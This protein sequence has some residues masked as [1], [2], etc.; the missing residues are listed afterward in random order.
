MRTPKKRRTARAP[1][2]IIATQ[3]DEAT[4]ARYQLE[5]VYCGKKTCTRCPH[6]PYWYAYLWAGPRTRSVYIGRTLKVLTPLET[7]AIRELARHPVPGNDPQQQLAALA[8]RAGLAANSRE[9]VA[10]LNSERSHGRR[11]RL[12]TAM[13]LERDAAAPLKAPLHKTPRQRARGT[14]QTQRLEAVVTPR[15]RRQAGRGKTVRRQRHTR[16]VDATV[17]SRL[18]GRRKAAKAV[19]RYFDATK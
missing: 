5:H 7:S 12:L 17:A 4:G 10:L 9:L 16:R 11:L 15:A 6:G 3:S 1:N 8:K 19:G 13:I 18:G 2:R 14:T